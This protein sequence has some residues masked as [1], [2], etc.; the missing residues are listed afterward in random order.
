MLS[1]QNAVCVPRCLGSR[2]GQSF[3]QSKCSNRL[4]QRHSAGVEPGW[5]YSRFAT[6]AASFAAGTYVTA[7]LSALG[8][9]G[10]LHIPPKQRRCY[11]QSSWARISSA[12]TQTRGFWR[13]HKIFCPE[14]GEA[15]KPIGIEAEI[16]RDDVRPVIARASQSTKAEARQ[17]LSAFF[18]SHF[19]DQHSA[20]PSPGE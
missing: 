11:C 14:G 6:I 2:A 16:D 19:R 12:S 18:T 10:N 5:R 7:S 13:I 17:E 3:S 15:V 20:P 8:T 1:C 9:A 4:R